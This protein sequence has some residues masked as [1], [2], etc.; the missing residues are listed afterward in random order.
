MSLSPTIVIRHATP[1]DQP[2]LAELAE[3]DSRPP[4]AGP[5]MLAEVDGTARAALD[6]ADGS[7]AADPFAPT[8][9]LVALL[10]LRARRLS[11]DHPRRSRRERVAARLHRPRRALS[12]RA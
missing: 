9:E 2:V 5:A 1:A 12:A 7:V 11:G 4:L 3:L 6:L 8:A 10:R